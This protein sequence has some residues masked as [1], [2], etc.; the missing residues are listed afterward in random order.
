MG[1]GGGCSK[2][3]LSLDGTLRCKLLNLSIM[4]KLKPP[5]TAVKPVAVT[6][7]AFYSG[8]IIFHI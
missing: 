3:G 8:D 2:E 1:V 5:K 4:K 6:F 7:Y